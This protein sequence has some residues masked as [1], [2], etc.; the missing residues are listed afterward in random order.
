MYKKQN[1]NLTEGVIWKTLILFTLP[2]LAGNFFQHL[3]TTA[4]A[5]I[6][7]KFTGKDGLAAID[8]I[9]SL[10]KLPLNFFTGLSIGAS[11]LVS[12]LFGGK[13]Q[14]ELSDTLHTAIALTCTA[15]IFLSVTGALLSP[16]LLIMM[17]VPEDIF[18]MTLSYVRIYF[19]GMFVSMFYNIG[20][21]IL[22][23][24]GNSKTPFYALIVSCIINIALDLILVGCFTW[25]IGGVAFATVIAQFLSAVII[26]AALLNK[27]G[28][29]PL[30]LLKIRIHPFSAAAITK[31]GLPLGAQS[32]FFPIA[33]MIIQAK[34]NSTGT[35]N[36]AAWA[37]CGKL[38]FL[39]WVSLEAITSSVSTFTAQN[40]GA[41]KYGRIKKITCA[42][43]VMSFCLIGFISTILY[44]FNVPLGKLF[45]S[46][47]DYGI[48]SMLEK[49][50]H[51]LSP[52]YILFVFAEIFSVIIQG[53][54]ET[55]KPML[56]T[57]L[58]ICVSRI[59]WILF[60]IPKI[61]SIEIIIWAF[62][63]SW[64]FTSLIFTV[65]YCI[66]SRMLIF[67]R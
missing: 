53:T 28:Q 60:I 30:H 67:S 50:M 15:G 40:Y 49:L 1:L 5:L 33:N 57:L 13:K 21:G 65:Y 29:A 41:K 45:I 37:L 6:I 16:F 47:K 26:F 34:I 52:F 18:E 36:I 38:D 42:G 43:L 39:I 46:A 55:F 59:V 63:L 62:P 10:L 19:A 48:L 22:R 56:L 7:G 25:G 24:M 51:I 54:G 64:T 8:S 31:L 4:D 9:Y 66:R 14:A 32:A 27:N 35:Y 11:I 12:Q 44:F 3:Y 61:S 2:I 17:G 20:A 58:G 23:A